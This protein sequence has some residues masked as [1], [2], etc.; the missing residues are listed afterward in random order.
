MCFPFLHRTNSESLVRYDWSPLGVSFSRKWRTDLIF[1]AI[2]SFL[3]VVLNRPFS[4]SGDP[5]SVAPAF[6]IRVP[7]RTSHFLSRGPSLLVKNRFPFPVISY[8][9]TFDRRT[10]YFKGLS[11]FDP[12]FSPRDDDCCFCAAVFFFEVMVSP[13]ILRRR[14]Y[15]DFVLI[16]CCS[17]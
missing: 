11:I 2:P 13:S 4:F 1:S 17:S 3:Q 8:L 15:V 10:C 12:F 7:L 9:L 16:S 5:L 6:L 14:S